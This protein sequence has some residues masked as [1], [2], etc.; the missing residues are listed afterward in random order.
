GRMLFF[1][2]R[3]SGDLTTSCASCHAPR[4]GWGDGQPL[5]RGYP[6]TQHWRNSQTVVNSAYLAKLFWAGESTSLESQADSAITGNLAGNGD[7]AM[8]E[9]RLAQAPDYVEM[10]REAFGTG[11]SYPLVLKAIA[12]FE[13]AETVTKDTPFD[14]YARG[15]PS[16]LP[17]SARRG[18]ELFAG[19]AACTSC[20]GGALFTDE[21]YHN[22]GVPD[23]P[24]FRKDPLRQISLR[25]QHLIRGVPEDVYRNATTD[26]GLYYTTKR[27]E[28]I[29]KFRTPPLRYINHTAPYMHNG[30]LPSLEEVVDFYDR[31]GDRGPGEKSPRMRP[32]GLAPEEKRNLVEFLKSLSGPEILIETPDLPKYA[33]AEVLT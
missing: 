13:R 17:E 26:L 18:M 8:V 6:G 25:Y 31:G 28:D 15:D 10:F 1:D 23:H 33:P 21:S 7:P 9:E 4:L 32:L 12:S 30:V 22:L 2:N 11:P 14:R 3:L 19:K 16:A 24:E 5:S 20:H 27:D 29:G